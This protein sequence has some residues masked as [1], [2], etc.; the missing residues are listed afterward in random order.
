MH[1]FTAY[2]SADGKTKV[3][4]FFQGPDHVQITKIRIKVSCG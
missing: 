2:L 1:V 4:M 3:N